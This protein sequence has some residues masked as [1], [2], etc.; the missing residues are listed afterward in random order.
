M[1]RVIRVAGLLWLA[2]QV[3]AAI[4]AQQEGS[5]STIAIAPAQGAAPAATLSGNARPAPVVTRHKVGIDGRDIAYRAEAGTLVID[6]AQGRPDAEMFYVAYVAEGIRDPGTRPLTFLFN[7]GPGSSSLWLHLGS[8]GPV[9]VDTVDADSTGPA[10]YRWRD[11][12]HSLL[13]RS[14]LVFIDAIGTGYSKGLPRAG[15]SDPGKRF[16]GTDQD[17]DAFARFVQRYLAVNQ[18][19]N[20]PKFLFGESY[21]TVR[22]AGLVKRLQDLGIESNGVVLMSSILNFGA[23]LPGFDHEFIHTLPTFA[24][25]AW[26]HGKV[27]GRNETQAQFLDEVRDFARGDYAI[28][29][30]RGNTLDAARS[31]AIAQRL[32]AYTGLSADYWKAAN[33]RVSIPRFR[34]ELLRGSGRSVGRYDG[35][36]LGLEGELAGE[37][38]SSD[39]SS[40][41]I[42]G[43]FYAALNGYLGGTLQYRRD[44]PYLLKAPLTKV[45]DWK[46]AVRDAQG[47]VLPVPLP[48]MT[49]DLADA[50]RANPRLK[51]LSANGLYDLSTPFSV[52]EYDL[53]HMDIG[54]ELLGNLRFTY[55]PSGHMMYLEPGSLVQLKQDL[56]RFYDDAA[57]RA[58]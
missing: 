51:V 34:R 53:A 15:D 24:A 10:P 29:L 9:R 17:I 57:P 48:V 2:L 33:L 35:R 16:W 55:Y 58:P 44:D 20:S 27:P 13:D 31:D 40:T 46:H 1:H 49:V 19:W 7:G 18:R 22:A 8:I 36:F 30:A 52:A 39:A 6:D 50:M 54:R 26:H 47:P 23:R 28:A 4:A 5:V 42:T 32:S 41:A 12:P 45:W 3:P 56:A 37:E 21:G 11:N 38:P 14:D 43:A 25:I